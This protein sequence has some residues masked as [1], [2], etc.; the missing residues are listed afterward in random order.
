M[1]CH[2]FAVPARRP[3]SANHHGESM[4]TANPL[5]AASH[6]FSVLVQGSPSLRGTTESMAPG[7]T[8][9]ARPTA[10]RMVLSPFALGSW[11]MT[12]GEVG[13]GFPFKPHRCKW[14]VAMGRSV[15]SFFWKI[16]LPALASAGGRGERELTGK[17]R[18]GDRP[19][20]VPC[21]RRSRAWVPWGAMLS[22]VPRDDREAPTTTAKACE[23]PT[24]LTHRS[25]PVQVGQSIHLDGDRDVV[26]RPGCW[27]GDAR[28]CRLAC[29]RR[30][31]S[32]FTVAAGTAESMAP[33][34]H[35][36]FLSHFSGNR[37][38]MSRNG[39][40][41]SRGSTFSVGRLPA[42]KSNRV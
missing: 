18:G 2:A 9:F 39:E 38:S 14:T 40:S 22:P 20:R 23:P 27:Q 3:G 15:V 29:F 37:T 28:S 33:G 17:E 4:R 25:L 12:P 6:A 30:T 32:G 36:V 41:P 42:D 8:Y 24:H 31:G 34:D 21:F 26:A 10:A 11:S 35:R 7:A 1:G 5:L 16:V 19:C 13:R